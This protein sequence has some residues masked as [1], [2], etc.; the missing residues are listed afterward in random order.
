MGARL[1]LFLACAAGQIRKEPG[2]RGGRARVLFGIFYDGLPGRWWITWLQWHSNSYMN[3]PWN[4]G[5]L[6][7][8]EN[9][10]PGS[11]LYRSAAEFN[12]AVGNGFRKEL[13]ACAL[14][15]RGTFISFPRTFLQLHAKLHIA[16]TT[17]SG[18]WK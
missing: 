12:Y 3:V 15:A 9:T 1:C 16:R 17:R 6:E 2:G 4:G 10:G 11:L 8:N 14:Q 7:P 5:F 13:N 18:A